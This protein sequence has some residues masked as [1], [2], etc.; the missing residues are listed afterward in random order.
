MLPPDDVLHEGA[1]A[2]VWEDIVSEIQK[3]G[4]LSSPSTLQDWNYIL[5]F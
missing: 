3:L 2:A 1:P 4:Q 5:S